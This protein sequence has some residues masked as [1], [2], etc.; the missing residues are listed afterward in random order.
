MT[1]GAGY[2]LPCFAYPRLRKL[3]QAYADGLRRQELQAARASWL[4]PMCLVTNSRGFISGKSIVWNLVCLDVSWLTQDPRRKPSLLQRAGGDTTSFPAT[5]STT[6]A[7]LRHV[8]TCIWLAIV[9]VGC[10]CCTCCGQVGCMRDRSAW[11]MFII[12]PSWGS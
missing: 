1:K 7:V 2:M 9:V 6:G 10:K 8:A 5:F 11:T 12:R 3:M 4:R